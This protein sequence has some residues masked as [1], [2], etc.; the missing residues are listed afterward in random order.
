MQSYIGKQISEEALNALGCLFNG[1][2]FT[3][4]LVFAGSAAVTV[5][6]VAKCHASLLSVNEVS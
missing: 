2:I 3:L 6:N 4:F 5:H 1:G